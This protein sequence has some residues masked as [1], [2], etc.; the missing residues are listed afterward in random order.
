MQESVTHLLHQ[1]SSMR[2]LFIESGGI[3][4]PL[5]S[6]YGSHQMLLKDHIF[7]I[8]GWRWVLHPET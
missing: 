5:K 1:E 2:I 8:D 3:L 6:G 7:R 4:R